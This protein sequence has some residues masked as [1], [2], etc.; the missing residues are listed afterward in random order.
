MLLT[1]FGGTLRPRFLVSRTSTSF[2]VAQFL[3]TKLAELR[4][5]TD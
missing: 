5:K 1:G 4:A 3:K 2:Q